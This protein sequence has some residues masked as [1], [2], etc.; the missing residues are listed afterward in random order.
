[1]FEITYNDKEVLEYYKECRKAYKSGVYDFTFENRFIIYHARL[2]KQLEYIAIDKLTGK[3]SH[4]TTRQPSNPIK[5]EEYKDMLR[6]IQYSIKYTGDQRYQTITN[7]DP[8]ELIETIFRVILP[9]NGYVI[10]EEQIKLSKTMFKGFTEKQ[11]A[12]CEAEVGTGKTL[13]YLV[14]AFVAKMF[15]E[16]EHNLIAPVTISTATVELQKSL[17]ERE[18]PHLSNLLQEYNIIKRPF[19]VSLRKGKE[20]YLCP[21][22]LETLEKDLRQN[23]EKH[24]GWLKT[25]ETVKKHPYGMDLDK[26]LIK[27]SIKSRICVKG[28]CLSCK[29]Q[30]NCPYNK[31][32]ET[33]SSSPF[34]DFQVTNHNLYL[35]SQKKRKGYNKS[36]LQ[37]SYFVVLDEAHRIKEVA[38]DVFGERLSEKDIITYVNGVKTCVADKSFKKEYNQLITKLLKENKTLFSIL[39]SELDAESLKNEVDENTVINPSASVIRKLNKIIGLIEEIELHKSKKRSN[40]N[41]TG[42]RLINTIEILVN[43]TMNTTW[44][45]KD[46]ND[47]LYL[48]CCSRYIDKILWT[49]VWDWESC[50]VL[51][52]GT[53]SDG[54][55]FEYFKKEV[56]IDNVEDH[57]LI[58]SSTSSPFDY[59]KNTRLYVPKNMPLPDNDS[60]AYVERI[61]EEILNI[62][63]ATNGHTAILFT[64]Y[65][66]LQEVHEKIKDELSAYQVFAMTRGNKRV[67]SDFRR[68]KN[69]ILFASGSMWEG[70]DCIGDCLSS[71]I[72]VRLPFP[73]RNAVTEERKKEYESVRE[74]VDEYCV[75]SM[76]MKLR[77]GAG[78]LVRSETDTGL[79]SV[80]DPRAETKVYSDK[81]MAA[82][83]KYPRVETLEDVQTFFKKVKN[84]D[85]FI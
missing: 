28:S 4:V 20:H 72:I 10:R 16:R 5:D 44:L 3:A 63:K 58:E 8:I 53:M 71:V 75:P 34:I 81:V 56:G 60:K 57:L 55:D 18:I 80:L 23:P 40:E 59:A 35:M 12:V 48:C 11:V 38:E 46:E 49:K 42:N 68:S 43:K 85:Y 64:S 1:M 66:V 13:A 22:R 52:S 54:D 21:V 33:A 6:D 36:L 70:V 41:I 76:L 84:E 65:K 7:E 17:V 74:F 73:L 31:M 26:Y 25:L 83:E 24:E 30:G 78:R 29:K 14:A 39:R 82:L 2:R 77:Q 51:T 50:H 32:M 19:V 79:I 47:I 15:Y 61:S 9:A 69:G 27:R 67:I 62:I 45:N 37:D